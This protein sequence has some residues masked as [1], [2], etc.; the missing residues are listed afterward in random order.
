VFKATHKALESLAK[1]NGYFIQRPSIQWIALGDFDSK[2]FLHHL[3]IKV[4]M[5][6]A[7]GS[8]VEVSTIEK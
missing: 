4:E 2:P 6:W 7:Q 5:W 8:K 3:Q 1:K